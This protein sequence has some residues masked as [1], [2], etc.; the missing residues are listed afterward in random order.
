LNDHSS[1]LFLNGSSFEVP[2]ASFDESCLWGGR[3]FAEGG[4]I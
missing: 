3:Q 2:I 4:E 1:S